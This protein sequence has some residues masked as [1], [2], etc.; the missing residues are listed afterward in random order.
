[1]ECTNCATTFEGNF[2]PNCGQKANLAR[3]SLKSVLAESIES[4]DIHRGFFKTS[5]FLFRDPGNEIR[6]HVLRKRLLFNPFKLLLITGTVATILSFQYT[7]FSAGSGAAEDGL[8]LGLV[9]IPRIAEYNYYSTKYFS[10]TNFVGVPLFALSTWLIFFR[11]GF[12]YYENLVLNIYIVC[13]QFY[14]I[15]AFVPIIVL[16]GYSNW[17]AYAL[18]VTTTVYNIWV[19]MVFFRTSFVVGILKSLLML[20]IGYVLAYF[21][22]YGLF[23]ILPES[24]LQFLEML[25]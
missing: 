18:F 17:A 3:Y 20:G 6:D 1:M 7:L 23:R 21:T 22:N 25:S 12:N 16:S 9:H 5:L 14:V 24:F 2:C 13:V 15:I 4:F 10:F 8:L 19:V 11:S